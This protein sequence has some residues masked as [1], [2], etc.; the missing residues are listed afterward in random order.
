MSTTLRVR[1]DDSWYTV[2]VGDLSA[3][4]VQVL[5]DGDPV[6]VDLRKLSAQMNSEA[7]VVVLPPAPAETEVPPEALPSR[8]DEVRDVPQEAPAP[9]APDAADRA[10]GPTK[11]FR[12]PMNG[13]IVS[14]AV[15]TGDQVVTGDEIC[16]LE[17]MKMHQT[18]RADWSGV[19]MGVHIEPGSQ[20][21]QGDL[22]VELE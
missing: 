3:N 8:E 7:E 9:T 5:V 19:V 20:V 13:T 21:E 18:L 6:E 2:E 1:I 12:V 10:P 11:E 16:V 22:I 4:P 15:R 17:A 14:V